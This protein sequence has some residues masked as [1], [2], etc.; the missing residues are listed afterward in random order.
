MALPRSIEDSNKQMRTAATDRL[1]AEHGVTL[2]KKKR[3]AEGI[4]EAI[5]SLESAIQ[6]DDA[7]TLI[8]AW[9]ALK[10]SAVVPARALP[11]SDRPYVISAAMRLA[12][13][14]AAFQP[15]LISMSSKVLYAPEYV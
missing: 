2:S 14:R 13:Q 6:S 7:M 9:V 3:G 8:R 4:A 15:P 1:R 11:T 10:P 5:R 12:A